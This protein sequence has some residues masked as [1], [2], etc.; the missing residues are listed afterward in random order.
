ME[1][2]FFVLPILLGL[3]APIAAHAATAQLNISA[4]VVSTCAV[5]TTPIDFGNYDGSQVDTTGQV[6]VTCN[7]GVPYTVA[8]DGG[9]NTDGANRLLSNGVGGLLPYRLTYV[10]VDWGDTGVTDTFAGNPVAS[11][12]T[13]TPEA[14]NVEARLFANQDA[15]PGV[16]TDTVT[17]TVAF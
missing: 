2:R 9:L 3:S 8:L 7:N 4:T 1:K 10:G 15:P 13:G 6:I 12:G 17:V 11:A 5:G 16:Y 14:F